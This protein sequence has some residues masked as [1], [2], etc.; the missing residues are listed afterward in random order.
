MY[1]NQFVYAVIAGLNSS[2]FSF[3]VKAINPL[4]NLAALSESLP[5]VKSRN[6][7]F[8]SQMFFIP[9]CICSKGAS[10]EQYATVARI[11]TWTIRFLSCSVLV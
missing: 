3:F 4:N 7:Y 10:S 8:R 2:I 1:S 5:L 11:S 9:S 6:S